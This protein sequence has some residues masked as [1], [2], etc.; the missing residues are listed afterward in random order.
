MGLFS[1]MWPNRN[2]ENLLDPYYQILKSYSDNAVKKAVFACLKESEYF[3]KPADIVKIINTDLKDLKHS[4]ELKKRYTCSVCHEQVSA[5]SDNKCLDCAGFPPADEK[6]VFLNS[7]DDNFVI[8]GRRQC[9]KCSTVS[10]CIKEPKDTGQW[11]C[12]KC[13]SGLTK[14]QIQQR[15]K[16]IVHM[17]ND[18]EFMPE[19]AKKNNDIPF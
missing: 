12:Q 18:K 9:Q 11:E 19:W 17:L 14:E 7:A 5:I 13:Y 16:D 8:E 6:Q 3:P 2:T 1:E 10:Q 4:Q 15:W